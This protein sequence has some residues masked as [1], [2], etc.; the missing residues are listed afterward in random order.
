MINFLKTRLFPTDYQAYSLIR[1][2]FD[3]R[4]IDETVQRV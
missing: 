4:F 3:A 2:T 1:Y